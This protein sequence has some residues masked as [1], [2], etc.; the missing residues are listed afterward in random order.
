MGNPRYWSK[1]PTYEWKKKNGMVE[2]RKKKNK[3]KDAKLVKALFDSLG[4][5]PKYVH[6]SVPRN[7]QCETLVM[8]RML[9]QGPNLAKAMARL[10]EKT[11]SWKRRDLQSFIKIDQELDEKLQEHLEEEFQRSK[12]YD[13]QIRERKKAERIAISEALGGETR[14]LKVTLR[15]DPMSES[16]AG[17]IKNRKY[18]FALRRLR[19]NF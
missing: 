6:I 13:A 1:T 16:L 14:D 4:I 8:Y 3:P 15:R 18:Q 12:M 9:G 11:S 19:E 5:P 17:V 7:A 2:W 10:K